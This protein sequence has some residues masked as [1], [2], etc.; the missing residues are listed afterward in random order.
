MLV[1]PSQ[2]LGF[3]VLSTHSC[4]FLLP[5]AGSATVLMTPNQLVQS[6]SFLPFPPEQLFSTCVGCIPFRIKRPFYRVS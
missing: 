4:V 1:H 6:P 3:N 5:I 2:A